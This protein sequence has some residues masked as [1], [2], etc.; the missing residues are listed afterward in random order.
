MSTNRIRAVAAWTTAVVALTASAPVVTADVD[1]SLNGEYIA[2]SDGQWAKTNEVF[3]DEQT[4]VST[5]TISSTC[6]NAYTCTGTVTSDHGWSADIRFTSD[7][8]FVER[9]LD[10]WERCVD[11]PP[12]PGHQVIKFFESR[13]AR[14]T[15]QG[16]DTTVG[17]SGACGINRALFIEMPF[18]L[19]PKQ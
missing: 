15:Y 12:A 11:G 16:W 2:T 3:R 7:M 10:D 17:P 6:T 9:A 13:Y 18:T 1:P 19:V 4:V 14:G 8:W 5:W